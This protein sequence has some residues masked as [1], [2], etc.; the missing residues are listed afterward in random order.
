MSEAQITERTFY[1]LL[2]AEIRKAGGQGV[3]EV[4][5]RS[6]P[7]IVFDFEGYRWILSVKIGQS[8]G[9]LKDAFL[10]YMRHKEESGIQF[11][12]LLLLPDS[13][14]ELP[15]VERE[16]RAAVQ[17]RNTAVL[18]DAG[19]V[20]EEL[21]DRPFPAILGFLKDE[22]IARLKKRKASYYSLPL[23]ISLLQ[24]QVSEMMK[25]IALEE[26]VILEVVTDRELLCDLG[27]LRPQQ[28]EEVGRF[29]ASYIL[30]SQVLFLRLLVSARPDLFAGPLSP[31]SHHRLREAFGKVL[32]VNYRPIYEI[33]VLDAI[34]DKFLKDTFDLIWGLE[35][36][37]VR[38]ELPGR[39]FHELMPHEIRKMLAAFYTRPQAADL[40]AH[41]TISQSDR[42]VFDPACGSGTILVSAYRRKQDL[43][44]SEGKAG[45]PHK[46][47]AEEEIYG[48]D[49]MPFAVHL[50]SANLA[51]MDPATTIDRTQIVQGDS[52]GLASGITYPGGI[53]Q[54]GMAI[55]H[56]APVARTSDGSTYVVPL[57]EVDTV[58]MNPPFTKVERGIKKFV[59]MD[60]FQDR[61]GGEVGLWGHFVAL[62]DDFLKP[63]GTYG[64]VLPINVLRGRESEKTRRILFEEWTPLYILKPTR[65]YAF[66]EWAEYR[67]ILFIA[68]KRKPEP[69]HKVKF[70]LV[71]RDLTK[72]AEDDVS[73][74]ADAVKNFD[75]LRS[76]DVDIDTHPLSDV[77]LRFA[78]MMWF[79]GVT[80][81]RHRDVLTRFVSR[82]SGRLARF[83]QNYFREGY[84]PVPKGVSQFLFL[85]RASHESRTK[86]AFLSFSSDKRSMITART[87]LGSSCAIAKTYLTPTLRTPV[88]I[89]T[90]D[91]TGCCDYIAHAPYP[92]L[93]RVLRATGQASKPQ[94]FWTGVQ[95]ELQEVSTCLVVARRINPFSPYTFLTAFFSGIA[96]S[97]SN[98][99]NVIR[100]RDPQRAQSVCVLLNSILFLA[101]FFLLK[102]ESTGR[103]I[104]VRFYD[105]EEMVLFPSDDVVPRLV[106]VFQKYRNVAFPSLR[107]QFDERFDDRYKEF[108]SRERT[109]QIGLFSAWAEPVRPYPAR[110][111]FDLAV[112][113]ALGV[114]ATPEDLLQVYDTIVK[115]M[116]VIRGLTRD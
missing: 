90:M 56:D 1:D 51:A 36:E 44:H 111:E 6:V 108:W 67:D 5:Y 19:E 91:I 50:T 31:V 13:V 97:P 70:C 61:V 46:R 15:P 9:T 34:P 64:A 25:D 24:Q 87:Q 40:L 60:R 81:L 57:T 30:L 68:Q 100:E 76:D 12:L 20:K 107:E 3:S 7:D 84:R 96:I 106:D 93:D 89:P 23:V 59:K 77:G 65:N 105:L 73:S 55:F 63:G 22:V 94:E 75:Y 114:P 17:F 4:R 92:D 99:L 35:I 10:Q 115:E 42:S 95:R 14:R 102:E 29:L 41:L 18:I 116:V 21:R 54:L 80:D 101:Q 83:P 32:E 109:G 62:A 74:V 82:F 103:Y 86:Q 43:F 71:K 45:N 39:I 2:L 69:D 16:L 33:D 72:L 47:F 37:R 88:G 53:R 113:E 8:I 112:C 110:L 78:N 38:Y 26:S 58:L 48:A 27:H 85:T 79:C 52:L 98:Q 28:V 66:S 104:D 11:G 49:I